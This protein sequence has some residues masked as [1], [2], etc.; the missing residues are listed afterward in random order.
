MQKRALKILVAC[1]SGI[2]TSTLAAAVVQEVMDGAGISCDIVKGP[3]LDVPTRAA[4]MD[5]V[6]TTGKY[7]E[8]VPVP[9]LSIT[10]FITGINDEPT[11]KK[12]AEMARE[13]VAAM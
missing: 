10:S 9:V 3:M 12:L 6:L 5:L 8:E 2:A 4:G 13:I 7:R 1:A 11:K